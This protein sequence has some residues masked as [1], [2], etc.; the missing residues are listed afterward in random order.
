MWLQTSATFYV[1]LQ[2][3]T[4]EVF[5]LAAERREKIGEDFETMYPSMVSA[6][7][8]YMF[9]Y[10]AVFLLT[11]IPSGSE[12]LPDRSHVTADLQGA[13]KDEDH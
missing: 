8:K 1:L 3:N 12:D 2:R 13:E 7:S 5:W 11:E 4:T 9:S 6:L 10:F